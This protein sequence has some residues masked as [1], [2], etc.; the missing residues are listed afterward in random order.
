M[1]NK[2]NKW[3]IG[4]RDP[5]GSPDVTVIVKVRHVFLFEMKA[6]MDAHTHNDALFLFC[7]E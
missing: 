7:F 6:L 3:R 5:E 4:G 2:E 1:M